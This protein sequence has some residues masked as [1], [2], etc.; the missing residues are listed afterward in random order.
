MSLIEEA[1]DVVRRRYG[2]AIG[3]SVETVTTPALLLDLPAA[4]RN[5]RRMADGIASLPATLRPHMKTH[6]SPDLALLQ[7][8]AGARGF[9]TATVWEAVILAEA[10]LD[11]L[12]VVNIVD[13]PAKIRCLVNLARTRRVLVAVDSF[14]NATRLSRE[15]DKSDVTLGVLIEIDTGMRRCGLD[16][17]AM[18][19]DLARRLVEL[20]GLRFEGVTGYEGHC[21]LEDD[22][23]RR[24]V[25]QRAAMEILLTAV[26]AIEAAGVACP[27]VSAGGTR[28]WWL[29]AATPGITEIQAGTYVLMDRFHSGVEGGF[30]PALRILT[31]VISRSKD[32]V[33]VDA[34]SK[35][36]AD[37]ELAAIAGHDVPNLGF[38]EEHGRF[39]APRDGDLSIGDVVQL[40]PGYAPSTVNLYDAYHVVEDGII[41]DIWPVIPRGPGHH[42]LAMN[43]LK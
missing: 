40:L 19:N 28:T 2:Q 13:G 14:A 25:M 1:R 26:A 6:K 15:A 41:V 34:G 18:A 42:G 33:I 10:G 3:Q 12:F 9:S 20:P 21:S 30:E 36:V 7:A 29:T 11:N 8:Q 17:P 39:A 24:T 37:P 27:I 38:D 23:G 4:R 31:T 5:I 22:V 32:R 35:S 43:G 16:E